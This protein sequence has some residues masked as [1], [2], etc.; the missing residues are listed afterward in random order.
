M[1]SC[2]M[3]CDL[4]QSLEAVEFLECEG[5][6]SGNTLVARVLADEKEL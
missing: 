2:A 1:C 6:C 3:L 4:C 5:K